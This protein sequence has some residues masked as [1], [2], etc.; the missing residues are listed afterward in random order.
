MRGVV[1]TLT[2]SL[3]SR[4]MRR[5]AVAFL[6]LS[7]LGVTLVGCGRLAWEAREAWRL[8]AERTCFASGLVTLSSSIS[9]L[10]EIDGPGTCGMVYPLRVSAFAGGSVGLATR[11]TLACPIIPQVETWLGRTVQPAAELYLGQRVV[12]IRG[13]SYSCRGRN[14]QPGAKVS[15]HAYGNAL[16]VMGF[17]LADGREIVVKTGWRGRP[18]EQDFLHEVFVGACRSFTTV[19]G[20]G[21]D[22]FHDDHLHLDLARHDPAG[23]RHVCRPILKFEPRLD[24]DRPA[25]RPA[26]APAPS[27]AADPPAEPDE[28]DDE[29]AGRPARVGALG[30]A[31]P[32]PRSR[33]G[34]TMGGAGIH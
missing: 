13:G 20:P 19:L 21:S 15:E 14:N 34:L 24:P 27:Q 10:P 4:R 8:Q 17:R 3:A 25:A 9:R 31:A 6:V 7:L 1:R 5:G 2:G 16:D 26:P 29:A 28:D 23:R 22:A 11:M 33:P 18:E 32:L 30:Q 12:E